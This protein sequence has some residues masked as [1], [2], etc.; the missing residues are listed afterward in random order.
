M[1]PPS[2]INNRIS[3]FTLIELVAVIVIL[4]ILGVGSSRLFSSSV[5]T[6]I[7]SRNQEKLSLEMWIALERISRELR[8]ATSLLTPL[9]G[10]TAST[11]RFRRNICFACVDSSR[12]ITFSHTP[13]DGKLWRL[14][15]GAG[16]RELA[17]NIS[18]FTVTVGLGSDEKKTVKISITRNAKTSGGE[19][20]SMTM[21]SVIHP[22]AMRNSTWMEIIR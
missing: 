18:S 2:G 20:S 6:F 16:R 17:D 21:E 22:Q 12:D 15:E 13:A 10:Q 14:S 7:A 3:G 4:G 8:H 1:A 11:L 19:V 5:D 9:A